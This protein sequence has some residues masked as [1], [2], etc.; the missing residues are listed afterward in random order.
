MHVFPL[1]QSALSALALSFHRQL[2]LS[3][4]PSYQGH[5][6]LGKICQ[7]SLVGV[8]FTLSAARNTHLFDDVRAQAVGYMSKYKSELRAV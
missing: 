8:S 7:E 5:A 4:R 6:M 2:V 3:A 1:P